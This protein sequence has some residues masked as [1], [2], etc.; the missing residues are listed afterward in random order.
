M[1]TR[2]TRAHTI[3]M[4]ITAVRIT[5][6]LSGEGVLIKCTLTE[7]NTAFYFFLLST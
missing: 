6:A 7:T 1:C 5:L 2:Y 4:I 3:V